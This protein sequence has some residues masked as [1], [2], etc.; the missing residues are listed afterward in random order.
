VVARP[1]DARFFVEVLANVLEAA[2]LSVVLIAKRIANIVKNAAKAPP[3]E[4][5]LQE[6]G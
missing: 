1:A 4:S 6:P 2:F 5:L 3:G